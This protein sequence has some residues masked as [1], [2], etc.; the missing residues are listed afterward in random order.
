[1]QARSAVGPEWEEERHPGEVL[2]FVMFDGGAY[3]DAVALNQPE[4][5]HNPRD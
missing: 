4:Y 3:W 1:M 5:L 2:P